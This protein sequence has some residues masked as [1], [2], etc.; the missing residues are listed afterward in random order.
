MGR[1]SKGKQFMT[2]KQRRDHKAGN[3][4]CKFRI[5][6]AAKT[7]DRGSRGYYANFGHIQDGKFTVKQ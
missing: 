2:R 4:M 6:R 3:Q 5:L 7:G 1:V